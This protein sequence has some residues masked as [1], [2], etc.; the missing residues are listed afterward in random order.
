MTVAHCTFPSMVSSVQS[1]SRVRLF[2]TPWTAARQTSLSITNSWACSNSCPSTWWCHPTISSSVVPFSSCPQ[3]LT[4]SGSFPVSQ[5]FASGG[6]S[7]GV[8]A[9]ASASPSMVP[10]FNTLFY[11]QPPKILLQSH[12]LWFL[13]SVTMAVLETQG[14]RCLPLWSPHCA[15][16]IINAYTIQSI[17]IHLELCYERKELASK[18]SRLTGETVL[19]RMRTYRF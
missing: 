1:L 4:A 10:A 19:I 9:S 14:W 16:P 2:T 18:R 5:F 3:S 12:W 8:S 6:Q 15:K 17:T 7:I 13:C 11:I